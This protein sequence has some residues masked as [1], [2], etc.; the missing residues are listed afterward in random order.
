[1]NIIIPAEALDAI[2]ALISQ[3]PSLTIKEAIELLNMTI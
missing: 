1:M 2:Q 3:D